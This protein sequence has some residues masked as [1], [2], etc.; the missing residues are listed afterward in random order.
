MT[1]F[2]RSALVATALFAGLGLS[3][4]AMAQGPELNDPIEPVNRAFFGLNE[5]LDTIAFKPIATIWNAVLPKPVRTGVGNVFGNL[6]DAFIGANHLLQGRGRDAMT[7]FSRVLV[8]STVGIGGLIDVAS[9]Q[10]LQKSEGDFGQTLGVWGAGPGFYLVLPLLGPSSAR[11]T[12][13]RAA[14]VASD[15]RTYMTPGWS[16]GLVGLEFVQIKADNVDN[17]KLIEASSLDKYAFTRNLYLQR[18]AAIVQS[19]REAAGAR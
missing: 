7:A 18:R 11:D 14:R 10:N 19:G 16:Y 13:G 6:D 17:A 15:P 3:S 12:V 4:A 2:V 8:N 5:A 1:C 9:T